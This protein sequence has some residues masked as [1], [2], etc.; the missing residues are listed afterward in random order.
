MKTKASITFGLV[1]VT[2]KDDSILSVNDKQDFVDIQDLKEDNIEEIKYATCEK[3]QF[4]LD[5]TFELMPDTL[6]NMCWWSNEMSDKK[7]KL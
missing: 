7:R 2:A 3:N 6:D 5:G 1:D 4:A